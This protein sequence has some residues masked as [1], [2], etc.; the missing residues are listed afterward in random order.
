MKVGV[1]IDQE[2]MVIKIIAAA[3]VDVV[4][5]SLAV[6]LCRCLERKCSSTCM[7]CSGKQRRY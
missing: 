2:E 7:D 3:A 4:Q 6:L 5:F 1:T